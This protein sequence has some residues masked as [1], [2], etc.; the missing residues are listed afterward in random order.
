MTEREVAEHTKSDLTITVGDLFCGI[1]GW[2]AGFKMYNAGMDGPFKVKWALD[3]WDRACGVHM[4]NHPAVPVDCV[5]IREA[6]PTDYE[7]VDVIVGSPPCPPFSSAKQWQKK[8]I[9]K[10][11]ELVEAYFRFVDRLKPKVFIMENVVPFKR[12]IEKKYIRNLPTEYKSF[13]MNGADHGLPQRR[14]RCI[15]S[16]IEEPKHRSPDAYTL[17]DV[18]DWLALPGDIPPSTVMNPLHYPQIVIGRN[19]DRHD[20]H[21]VK[22]E[23]IVKLFK[24]KMMKENAGYVQFPDPLDKPARTMVA[25]PSPIG[26]EPVVVLDQRFRP[27]KLRYLSLREQLLI[28]GFSADYVLSDSSKTNTQVMIGNAFPPLMVKVLAV[29]IWNKV[30]GIS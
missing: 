4:H 21:E 2:S 19:A 20:L 15:L 23:H 22:E 14:R 8:D 7:S 25:K 12:F 26:R 28:Q 16:N 3:N 1:G 13:V 9:R 24:K 17:G 18:L 10:G 5:D 11:F 30:R 27:N 29:E 6:D